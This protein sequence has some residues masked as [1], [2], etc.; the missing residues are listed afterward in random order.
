MNDIEAAL[1]AIAREEHVRSEHEATH[2][3]AEMCG[4]ECIALG[5]AEFDPSDC[6][7]CGEWRDAADADC[8]NCGD[9]GDDRTPD[10]VDDDLDAMA[11]G[12]FV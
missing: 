8:A 4:A 9:S 2:G 3:E 11:P 10:Q 5:L 1:D 6:P 7:K 12:N